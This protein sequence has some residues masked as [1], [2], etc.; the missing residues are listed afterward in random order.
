MSQQGGEVTLKYYLTGTPK[1]GELRADFS[2]LGLT[3]TQS[4]Q[5]EKGMATIED[6]IIS[7]WSFDTRQGRIRSTSIPI[8][9]TNP[10]GGTYEGVDMTVPL[11]GGENGDANNVRLTIPA[12][13]FNGSS[14]SAQITVDGHG[15][16]NVK[17]E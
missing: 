12:G 5:V 4:T 7:F 10:N 9:Y 1:A 15:I 8:P 6:K 17:K 16:F 13:T 14:I 11:T 3:A 2:R